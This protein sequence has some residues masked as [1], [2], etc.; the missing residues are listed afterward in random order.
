M[1]WSVLNIG[2]MIGSHDLDNGRKKMIRWR[3]AVSSSCT[4]LHNLGLADPGT[5]SQQQGIHVHGVLC[6]ETS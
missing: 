4:W 6:E 3:L 1:P 5:T 2:Q